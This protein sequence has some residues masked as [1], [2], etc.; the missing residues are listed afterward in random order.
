[1]EKIKININTFDLIPMGID[2]SDKSR[3]FT[4]SSTLPPAEIESAFTNVERIEYLSE[5]DEILVTYLDGI[6]LKFI[7]RNYEDDTYTITISTDA[8]ERQ[9]KELQA[10]VSSLM[11]G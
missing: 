3:T 7:Q 6:S 1:M 4:I 8:I 10:Q 2:Q 5:S 11:G 9:I